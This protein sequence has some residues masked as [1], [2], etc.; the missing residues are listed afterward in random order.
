MTRVWIALGSNLGARLERLEGAVAELRAVPGLEVL[1]V[2]P[3][4]ETAPVGGPAGQGAYLNGVLEAETTLAP[5]ELLEL[6]LEVE[7]RNGRDRPREQ[8]HGP[9]TLDLDLLFHGDLAIDEPGLTLPHPRI[10]ER[11][12]VLEPMA[13]LEPTKRLVSGLT[14]AERLR[15][16]A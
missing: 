6:L 9:R 5:R 16:L 10:E 4:I 8:R 3:W 15:Q 7:R 11:V 13:R 2:S 12:F 14:V 1:R